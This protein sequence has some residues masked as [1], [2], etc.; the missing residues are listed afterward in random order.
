M[1][2]ATLSLGHS[3]AHNN[4]EAVRRMLNI[5]G[6]DSIGFNEASHADVLDVIRGAKPWRLHAFDGADQ[7]EP[8]V[9]ANPIAVRHR[10]ANIGEAH[11]QIAEAAE[12]RRLAPPRVATVA[13]YDHPLG[14]VAHLSVH[15]H[16]GVENASPD[17][18]RRRQHEASVGNIADI[19][20]TLKA[21]AD[22]V[23]VTGDVNVR[24]DSDLPVTPAKTLRSLGFKVW[25]EGL[26]LMAMS[27]S[28]GEPTHRRVYSREEIGT[29]HPSLVGRWSR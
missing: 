7:I 16:A 17:A 6:L 23:A 15:L 20:V 13:I 10:L 25:Q 24:P 19:V 9:R 18:R 14:R 3:N 11:L 28:L 8:R 5:S 27:R 26:D 4:P 1:T 12:P 29:D 21:L 22:H 2:K